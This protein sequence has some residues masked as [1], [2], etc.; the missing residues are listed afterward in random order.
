MSSKEDPQSRY[1]MRRMHIRLMLP[2]IQRWSTYML[3][4]KSTYDDFIVTYDGTC[5]FHLYSV[6][7]PH[8]PMYSMVFL[9]SEVLTI[10]EID[11][12]FMFERFKKNYGVSVKLRSRF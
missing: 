4:A 11:S 5:V 9:P 7:G 8:W 10:H 1:A 3:F 6:I 12:K 2:E